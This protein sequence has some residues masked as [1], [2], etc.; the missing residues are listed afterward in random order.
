MNVVGIVEHYARRT[1]RSCISS[2][3]ASVTIC[4]LF[5]FAIVIVVIVAIVL[6]RIVYVYTL[7]YICM[8]CYSLL[9]YNYLYV[10]VSI[11]L[12]MQDGST[13]RRNIVNIF[14]IGGD[15]SLLLVQPIC[16]SRTI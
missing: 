8:Y 14:L 2:L 6:S 12:M 11:S 5:R 16:R 15:D 10:H 4:I 9:N 13:V 3:D 1:K 7:V